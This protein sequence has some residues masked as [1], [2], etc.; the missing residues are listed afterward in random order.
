MDILNPPQS[1]TSTCPFPALVTNPNAHAIHV[2]A[3]VQTE[4]STPASSPPSTIIPSLNDPAPASVTLDNNNNNNSSNSN[5]ITCASPPSPASLPPSSPSPSPSPSPSSASSPN[6]TPN[7]NV[8]SRR[9]SASAS[10]S[11]TPAFSISC[12]RPLVRTQSWQAHFVASSLV[13]PPPRSDAD[14]DMKPGNIRNQTINIIPSDFSLS[15]APSCSTAAPAPSD[16]I[17]PISPTRSRS[18]SD[19]DAGDNYEAS[20]SSFDEDERS[21]SGITPRSRARER[22]RARMGAIGAYE[23]REMEQETTLGARSRSSFGSESSSHSRYV[24]A[25]GASLSCQQKSDVYIRI[26]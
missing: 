2:L 12:S 3:Q 18:G 4:T 8:G 11:P 21:I 20:Q 16:Q 6:C 7:R 24:Y 1:T 22:M 5:L 13:P 25:R 15:S 23:S 9:C 17:L 10:P 26:Y 14:L 19:T